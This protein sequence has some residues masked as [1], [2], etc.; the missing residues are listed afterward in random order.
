ML[1]YSTPGS[2]SHPHTHTRRAYM[3]HIRLTYRETI[4]DKWTFWTAQVVVLSSS[5][6]RPPHHQ[7]TC[8]DILSN[9]LLMYLRPQLQSTFLKMCL[10]FKHP[11]KRW[12]MQHIVG[13]FGSQTKWQCLSRWSFLEYCIVLCAVRLLRSN[14]HRRQKRYRTKLHWSLIA[15]D[16]RPWHGP[17]FSARNAA[18]RPRIN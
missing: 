16:V 18:V 5:F 1:R 4:L 7:I 13:F 11:L 8:N 17:L 2:S 9:H 14:T 12:H 6:V 10:C 15:L 3:V